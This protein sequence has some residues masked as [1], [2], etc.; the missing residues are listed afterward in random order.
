M[1]SYPILSDDKQSKLGQKKA[2]AGKGNALPAMSIMFA[3]CPPHRPIL[4]SS[5]LASF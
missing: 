3:A 5:L 4:F 1:E 2:F